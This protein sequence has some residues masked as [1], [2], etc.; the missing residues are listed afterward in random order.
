MHLRAVQEGTE[1]IGNIVRAWCRN[2]GE[3][4]Y[5]RIKLI[6]CAVKRSSINAVATSAFDLSDTRRHNVRCGTHTFASMTLRVYYTRSVNKPFL[7]YKFI[8]VRKNIALQCVHTTM[9][10]YPIYL[11]DFRIQATFDFSL[12][13]FWCVLRWLAQYMRILKYLIWVK[14]SFSFCGDI[15]SHPKRMCMNERAFTFVE[16]FFRVHSNWDWGCVEGLWK[17]DN[18]YLEKNYWDLNMY[19]YDNK[20]FLIFIIPKCLWKFTK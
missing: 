8:Y 14:S 13:F 17:K 2:K 3:R 5:K 7:K 1:N 11:H 12:T 4:I 15:F 6:H 18:T 16:F 9:T 19:I 20:I 10:S